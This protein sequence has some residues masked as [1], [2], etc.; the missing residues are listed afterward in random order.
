MICGRVRMQGSKSIC[1][2]SAR[3]GHFDETGR[4]KTDWANGRLM[5]EIQRR[6]KGDFSIAMYS[7]PSDRNFDFLLA[8]H[9]AYSLPFPFSYWGG[10]LNAIKTIRIFRRIEKENDI[11]IIQLPIVSFIPLF[12]MQKPVLFH[13]CANIRAGAGNALKYKGLRR[14]G[15]VLAAAIMHQG[16]RLLFKRKKNRLLVNGAELARLYSEFNPV[17]VVS[18]SVRTAEVKSYAAIRERNSGEPFRIVFVGRPD[19]VKGFPFLLDSFHEL[20]LRGADV[21]LSIVGTTFEE[22]V[23]IMGIDVSSEF[24]DSITFHGVLTWGP[25]YVQIM[26]S[27]HCLVLPSIS[28]GTPRV[29]IEARALGCPVIAANVGGIPSSITHEVDGILVPVKNTDEIV[30]GVMRLMKDENF[31]QQLIKNGLETSKRFSLENFAKVFISAI[32]SYV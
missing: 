26:E 5:S 18:G 25:E 29:L 24:K 19:K 20:L 8:P 2:V 27:G 16:F 3:T 11:L 6:W 10:V 13:V 7:N 32:E 4:V 17:T 14:M 15:A 21:K 12:F 28:E 30:E 22:L 1:F 31:R 23:G 9:K